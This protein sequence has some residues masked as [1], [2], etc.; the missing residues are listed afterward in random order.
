MANMQNPLPDTS[1]Y[2]DSFGSIGGVY[3]LTHAHADH[4]QGLRRGWRNGL[5]YC[6]K[7]TA[8]ILVYRKI[9]LPSVLRVQHLEQPFEVVDPKHPRLP[10]TATFLDANHCPGSVMVALEWPSGAAVLN[11]GD[12]RYDEAMWTSPTLRRIVNSKS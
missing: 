11:T 1:I 9:V 5:L 8:D 12:F 2:I 10:V 6:S 4:T 3:F 7:I